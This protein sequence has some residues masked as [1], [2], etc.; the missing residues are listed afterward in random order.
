M[1]RSALTGGVARTA[2]WLRENAR[3]LPALVLLFSLPLAH[4]VAL[5]L[6]CL[7]L[8]FLLAA[9]V[10]LREGR[11]LPC[12]GP[13]ALWSAIAVASLAWSVRPGYSLGELRTEILYPLLAFLAFHATIRDEAPWRAAVAALAA[14]ILVV[15]VLAARYV[16]SALQWHLQDTGALL[17]D[18]NQVSTAL[19]LVAPV[20]AAF[21]I[22][23]PVGGPRLRAALAVG[24]ALY[25]V[26]ALETGNRTLW[27]ALAGQIAVFSGLY[28]WREAPARAV[29]VR[30]AAG[31]GLVCAA[32]LTLFALSSYSK[33]GEVPLDARGLQA[34]LEQSVRP[35]I[36]SLALGKW[37]ER[38]LLGHGFGREIVRDHLVQADARFATHAH[39][40]PLN[41]A[42]ELGLVGLA[43]YALL[44]ACLARRFWQCLF[45]PERGARILGMAGLCLLVGALAKGATDV[46][47]VRGNGLL[48]WALAGM[49][50]G[51]ARGAQARAGGG[52]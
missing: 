33:S 39:N 13:L 24:G 12:L 20:F 47:L 37:A 7:G 4:T 44:L 28:L 25:L 1:D 9:P 48:F 14:G 46:P 18:V 29:S 22:R 8:A 15:A 43:A 26:T 32:M 5:R 42:L 27:L 50:L 35:Q 6:A 10:I 52:S 45:A 41:V 36:W 17:A 31:A 19:V 40:L 2:G 51:L 3:R 23:G 16:G 21:A 30:V 34:N 49:L 38:P 11:R